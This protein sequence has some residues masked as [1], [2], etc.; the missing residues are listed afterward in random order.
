MLF[1]L[2]EGKIMKNNF[3]DKYVVDARLSGKLVLFLNIWARHKK[4]KRWAIGMSELPLLVKRGT[5]DL[6]NT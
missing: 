6:P 2:L 3:H 5:Y 4:L 1:Q